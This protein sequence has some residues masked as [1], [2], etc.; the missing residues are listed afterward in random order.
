MRLG[1]F[2][3][4]IGQLKINFRQDNLVYVDKMY[5]FYTSVFLAIRTL[6]MIYFG[7]SVNEASRNGILSILR[8]A[9]TANWCDDVS[10]NR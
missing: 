7:A 10:Q 9:P 3:I 1:K 4:V 6:G 5:Y 2:L 8:E